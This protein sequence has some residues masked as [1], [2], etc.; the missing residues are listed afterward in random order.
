MSAGGFQ[1]RVAPVIDNKVQEFLLV[2]SFGDMK[3]VCCMGLSHHGLRFDVSL[4]HFGTTISDSVL[5]LLKKR[6]LR[7]CTIS[8]QYGRVPT[9]CIHK[10]SDTVPGQI[11]G[12]SM[13]QRMGG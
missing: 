11:R 6:E 10:L 8:A 1:R 7:P 2:E 4:R 13:G 12:G 5:V 3:S 9:L